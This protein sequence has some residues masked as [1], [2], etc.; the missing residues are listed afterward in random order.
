MDCAAAM[1]VVAAVN[2]PAIR[3]LSICLVILGVVFWG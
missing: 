2:M 1:P 3:Y